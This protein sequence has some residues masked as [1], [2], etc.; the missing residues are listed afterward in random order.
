MVISLAG[1]VSGAT[2]AE[3]LPVAS[4]VRTADAVCGR[5]HQEILQ[6]YL[7]T[8]MANASGL[9][10]DNFK[11]GT[12]HHVSSGVAYE[13]RLQNGKAT[14]TYQKS[15]KNGNK[16]D[17][18]LDYFLGSGHLGTT[19]L[20][21]IDG[22]L[23]ESP[24][25]YYSASKKIDM[26]PGLDAATGLLPALPMES[27]C[28]RCHMSGV[29]HSDAGTL[30]HYREL[31]FLHT[32]ITCEACHGDTQQHVLSGGKAAVINPAKLE[33][34]RRDSICISCHLE[35]DISVNRP[36]RSAI[37]FKPGDAISDYLS[38]FVFAG[39]DPTQRGVSEVEQFSQSMCK[40]ESGDRMSCASCHDP[41][42]TP[43]AIDRV[44]FY[45]HKCLI[46]HNQTAFAATHHPENPDCTSCHMP[47]SGAE[48]I[49][50]VSWTDHRIRRVPDVEPDRKGLKESAAL[51]PVFSPRST[52]RDLAV[53][54]YLAVMDGNFDFAQRAYQ[55]LE[56][57]KPSL[58]TDAEALNALGILTSK[59]GNNQAAITF[60]EQTLRTDPDNLT[61]L[62]NLGALRAKSGNLQDAIAIWQPVFER[63]QD[64][65]G[66]AKNLAMIE[67][68]TGDIASARETLQ[69]TLR[70]NPGLEDAQRMLEKLP[71]CSAVRQ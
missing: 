71:S 57:I 17:W 43:E 69:K 60:F 20:Y 23:F 31:A 51:V 64:V 30:N 65:V 22:Y 16:V 6:K 55:L 36:G 15:S 62:M 2:N 25:A 37:D 5:C 27:G 56:S 19:Y 21:S 53:A 41:H 13:L 18:N 14:L 40:R 50:H 35:G 61:A 7:A 33:P 29:Q 48:N 8:P 9:A 1:I 32:G 46:C 66:L 49:P 26:K 4:P 70:Y 68:M 34:G 11:A 58:S 59:S 38:F 45:R 54:N 52:E 42:Y 44:A 28:L 12:F 63:N 67:C 10:A 24:V 39:K 3:R 47:R